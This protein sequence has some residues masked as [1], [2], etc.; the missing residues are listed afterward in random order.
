MN[1]HIVKPR[2][3][4][5]TVRDAYRWTFG[6]V[7]KHIVWVSAGSMFQFLVPCARIIKSGLMN[8]HTGIV[9]HIVDA[10]SEVGW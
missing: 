3:N 5:T 9:K 8:K 2:S 10:V 4:N 7:G 1:K 6:D